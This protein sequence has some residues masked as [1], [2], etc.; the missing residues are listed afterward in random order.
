MEAALEV[1]GLV[2]QSRSARSA[3]SRTLI[4]MQST[5]TESR[6]HTLSTDKTQRQRS[7]KESASAVGRVDL[8]H[9]NLAARYLSESGANL[10]APDYIAGCVGRRSR[11]T[12]TRLVIRVEFEQQL[13]SHRFCA[14]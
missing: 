4:G 10:K 6:H 11:S 3:V 7:P 14:P 2:A 9:E 1:V 12:D 8:Q 13:L 5:S